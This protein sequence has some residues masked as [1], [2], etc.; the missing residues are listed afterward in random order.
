MIHRPNKKAVMTGIGLMI[1]GVVCLMI[2]FFSGYGT[3]LIPVG[4][5]IFCIGG[6]TLTIA[7]FVALR[8]N[9]M[10]ENKRLREEKAA[11]EE[12]TSK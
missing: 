12:K 2:K 10:E 1:L 6:L 8:K 7:T 4:V 5:L 9:D 11:E 3:F